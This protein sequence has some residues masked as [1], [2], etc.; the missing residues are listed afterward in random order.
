MQLD[1]RPFFEYYRVDATYDQKTS[2]FECEIFIPVAP[3]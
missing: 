3:L 2:E 1:S